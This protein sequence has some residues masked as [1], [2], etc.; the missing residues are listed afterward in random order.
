MRM[1]NIRPCDD[2][3]PLLVMADDLFGDMQLNAIEQTGNLYKTASWCNLM[4]IAYSNVGRHAH[5]AYHQ[6]PT[7]RY[8][9]FGSDYKV[10]LG[11][12]FHIAM[13][14]TV[15]FNVVD[16]LYET[17]VGNAVAPQR[18]TFHEPNTKYRGR[19]DGPTHAVRQ[20]WESS[21][22]ARDRAC[23]GSRAHAFPADKPPKYST[24]PCAY[25]WVVTWARILRYR[26]RS[27]CRRPCAS[28][29]QRDRVARQGQ[30]PRQSADRLVCRG[31]Q[32]HL[33]A[34]AGEC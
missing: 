22:L 20:E 12:G 24:S 10:H 25:G 21:L 13:A 23:N 5:V 34:S 26:I 2:D 31:D 28:P 29:G 15:L 33:L 6:N 27:N 19:Y 4:T 18:T 11:I 32:R 1:H 17:C 16:A 8:P 30:A 9:L 7:H 14:W 3:L